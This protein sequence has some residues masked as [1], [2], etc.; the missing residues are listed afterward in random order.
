[1]LQLEL[2]PVLN[3][4]DVLVFPSKLIVTGTSVC[5]ECDA[6]KIGHSSGVMK[7]PSC[8]LGYKST[9]TASSYFAIKNA[10]GLKD[11]AEKKMAECI[12]EDDLVG[13]YAAERMGSEARKALKTLGYKDTADLTNNKD[14]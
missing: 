13:Y 6:F 4:D 8:D 2:N 12:K 3:E 9:L 11:F 1:M 10:L 14:E 5:E 7:C